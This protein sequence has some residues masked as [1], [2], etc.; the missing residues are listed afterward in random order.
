VNL[1]V[2]CDPKAGARYSNNRDAALMVVELVEMGNDAGLR[3]TLSV[4]VG[5]MEFVENVREL[6]DM[7]M[8]AANRL[9]IIT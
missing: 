1:V 5:S 4:E 6:R 9:R 7:G 2:K 3:G 8:I